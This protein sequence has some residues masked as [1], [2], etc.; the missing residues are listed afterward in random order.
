MTDKIIDSILKNEDPGHIEYRSGPHCN[1]CPLQGNCVLHKM[2]V[3]NSDILLDK[4]K[5]RK[6]EAELLNEYNEL[7]SL[8]MSVNSRI[9]AIKNSAKLKKALDSGYDYKSRVKTTTDIKSEFLI[10]NI[11]ETYGETI[12]TDLL[13]ILLQENNLKINK[14]SLESLPPEIRNLIENSK[15]E[16]LSEEIMF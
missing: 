2:A 11:K 4:P 8:Q 16:R 12:S 1:Y 10:K 7:K 14:K 13:K 9:D 3:D 6:T 5:K 15:S